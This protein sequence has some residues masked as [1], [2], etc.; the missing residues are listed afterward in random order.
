MKVSSIYVRDAK[1]GLTKW[2]KENQFFT[3]EDLHVVEAYD[4][5]ETNCI[6]YEFQAYGPH[7]TEQ[8]IYRVQYL[9]GADWYKV[10]CLIREKTGKFDTRDAQLGY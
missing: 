1:Q 4:S 10:D 9:K 3:P 8:H 6:F 2:I 5:K 7:N